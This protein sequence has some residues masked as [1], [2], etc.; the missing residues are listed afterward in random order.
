MYNLVCCPTSSCYR[1]IPKIGLGLLKALF[2]RLNIRV[3]GGGGGSTEGSVRFQIV[4]LASLI[5]ESKFT[6][7][8]L[9][10]CIC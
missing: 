9:F 8:V 7:F 5:I 4:D 1:K 2:E 10:I 6:V 3:G